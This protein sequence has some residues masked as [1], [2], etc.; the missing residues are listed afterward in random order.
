LFAVYGAD[1]IVDA[2]LDVWYVEAQA[3]PGFGESYDYR[4]DLFRELYRPMVD[5]VEEIARKQV[6]DA[7]ANLLPLSTLGGWEIV[8]AGDWMY[9][10][11]GYERDAPD[12][13]KSCKV[14]ES[15]KG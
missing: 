5:I 14:Q 9:T 6:A 12:N 15:R 11:K 8:Y 13:K 7:R 10:Y 4:V 2:D 3:S 1:F